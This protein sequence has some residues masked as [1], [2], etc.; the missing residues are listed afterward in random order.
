MRIRTLAFREEVLNFMVPPTIC[1][2]LAKVLVAS[3]HFFS[4]RSVRNLIIDLLLVFTVLVNRVLPEK[5]QGTGIRWQ[6]S[7]STSLMNIVFE[8]ST[9]TNTSH[10]GMYVFFAIFINLIHS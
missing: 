8:T 7:Q 4:Y 2:S 10:Q 5:P 9:E 6:V 1:T 3:T